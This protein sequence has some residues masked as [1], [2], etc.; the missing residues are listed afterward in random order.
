MSLEK[1]QKL[2]PRIV[3]QLVTGSSRIV[4]SNLKSF[5]KTLFGLTHSVAGEPAIYEHNCKSKYV[6]NSLSRI[7]MDLIYSKLASKGQVKMNCEMTCGFSR[8]GGLFHCKW[9]IL[10]QK[11]Q[12]EPDILVRGLIVYIYIV[13]QKQAWTEARQSW[14]RSLLQIQQ[15]RMN[16]GISKHNILPPMMSRYV[17]IL[18]CMINSVISVHSSSLK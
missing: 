2:C 8:S 10:G 6:W 7:L 16:T 15:V 1:P 13:S 9:G 11:L 18:W 17:L 14:W 3:E 12:S 5:I 4:A